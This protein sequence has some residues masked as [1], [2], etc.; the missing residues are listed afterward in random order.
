MAAPVLTKAVNREAA[1]IPFPQHFPA[2]LWHLLA[3]LLCESVAHEKGKEGAGAAPA[4]SPIAPDSTQPFCVSD[5]MCDFRGGCTV[6][7][8][9]RP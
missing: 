6:F 2:A 8:C 1:P 9:A 5:L 4:E 3:D 7:Q